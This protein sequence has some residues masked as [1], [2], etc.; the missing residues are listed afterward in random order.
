MPGEDLEFY[1]RNTSSFYQRYWN[2]DGTAAS[3]SIT[4]AE[5]LNQHAGALPQQTHPVSGEVVSELGE[6]PVIIDGHASFGSSDMD[7]RNSSH[8]TSKCYTLWHKD[9][10]YYN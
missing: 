6:R 1:I 9:A 7:R 2:Q 3:G 5:L 8:H 4:V 10:P